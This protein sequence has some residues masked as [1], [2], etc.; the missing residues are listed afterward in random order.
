[1]LSPA[2]ADVRS[3]APD[4]YEFGPGLAV[5]IRGERRARDYFRAEYDSAAVASA[6]GAP[7]V[8]A[9]I[10][11]RPDRGGGDG[12]TH[13]PQL[14]GAHK[15]ARWHASLPLAAEGDTMRVAV[16][17]RGPLGLAL[18]QS[19]VIE[20]LVS[21]AA[22]RCGS[23]LLPGAAIVREGETVLLIGRSR[24]GKSSLAARALAAGLR[25][26]GDDQVLI[27]ARRECLPFPR[28]LRLYP[29]LIRTAP[30]AFARLRPS[31]QRRL[32]A[33]SHVNALT[34]GYVAP[35]LSVSPASLSPGAPAKVA[36]AVGEVVVIRRAPVEALSSERLDP[37]ELRT[38]VEDVLRAQR[39]EIFGV[40]GM[41][42]S[43]QA[44]LD[45]ER[46]IV[47][48][49]LDAAPARRVSVPACWSSER[50]VGA[51]AHELQLGA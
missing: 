6:S 2:G 19:Y 1:M 41:Q 3:A 21:L 26:L 29:D 51:L 14:H 10:G 31:V 12:P 8:E 33:L 22:I 15:L 49:A 18:V 24:S 37:G 39:A 35:P 9:T 38:E 34:R 23:V 25:V 27:N 4:L 13:P 7:A 17:V 43:Y 47:A 50:A 5:S 20:P 40:P 16:D 42:A 32:A 46:A 45:R 36:P 28:R 44:W 11:A 30:A 48:G